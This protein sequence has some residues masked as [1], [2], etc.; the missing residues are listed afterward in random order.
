M[1]ALLRALHQECAVSCAELSSRYPQFA[2][3]SVYRHATARGDVD[4]TDRRRFNRGCPKKLG[5]RDERLIVRTL[6]RLRNERAS[7]SSRRI[8]EETGLLRVSLKTIQRVLRRNGYTYRQSRK[9]G[10]LSAADRAKRLRY[11]RAVRGKAIGYWTRDIAFY[12]DGVGFAHRRNPY[13]EA[14]SVSSMAWRKPGEGLQITTKGRKEGSN[15]KMANF[16]VAISHGSG[17]VLCEHHDWQVTGA[18]FADFVKDHF[19]GMYIQ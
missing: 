13:A 2:R 14:R 12:F 7:F 8:Q 10:L 18:R 9:K 16:F 1:S 3:R 17:V 15:G 19:P 4:L 6:L 11:A 5:D